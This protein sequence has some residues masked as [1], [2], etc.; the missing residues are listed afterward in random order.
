M[1]HGGDACHHGMYKLEQLHLI[2]CGLAILGVPS[3]LPLPFPCKVVGQLLYLAPVFFIVPQASMHCR[4][5]H[6]VQSSAFPVVALQ[7]CCIAVQ[8]SRA[9]RG[10]RQEGH[11]REVN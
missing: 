7:C 6:K 9:L 10:K 2:P 5:N 8:G 1:P 11:G 4:T 3:D